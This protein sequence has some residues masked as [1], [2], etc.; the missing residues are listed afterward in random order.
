MICAALKSKLGDVERVNN[1]GNTTALAAPPVTTSLPNL[2]AM[3]YFS[4]SSD[5]AFCFLFRAFEKSESVSLSVMSDSC[6]L[7]SSLVHGILQARILEWIATPFSRGSSQPRDRTRVSCTAG[8]FFTVWA[9]RGQEERQGWGWGLYLSRC[10]H[11]SLMRFWKQSR[12]Y[13]QV[14]QIGC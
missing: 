9:T 3:I 13:S 8:Q 4:E 12:W 6:G 10:P 7:P 2:P 1:A 14:S 5:T 11:L